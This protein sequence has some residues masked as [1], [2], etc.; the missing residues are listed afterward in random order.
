MTLALGGVFIH[1]LERERSG[2]SNPFWIY[3]LVMALWGNLHGG[4]AIG[5]ILIGAY[6]G[7]EVFILSG[8]IIK[9][10]TNRR[11]DLEL[12]VPVFRRYLWIVLISLMGL[13]LNPNGPA[14]VLYPFKT[15]S[16]G[17][18][19][20]YIQ[21]WQSPDFH[22]LGVQPFLWMLLLAFV[23]FGI[24]K[25]RTH[26]TDYLLVLGFAVM[27]FWAARNIAIFALAAIIPISRAI[28]SIPIKIAWK[29]S[30]RQVSVSAQRYVNTFLA[31][32]FLT[33]ALLKI[34]I[35][36]NNIYNQ[37]IIAETFPSSAITHL[38]SS[39]SPAPIF[40]SYNWGAYLIWELYPEYRSFVDGRTDLFNDEILEQYLTAWRGEPGWMEI[41]DRWG[42]EL[43]LIEPHSPLATKL[44]I[45]GWQLEYEDSQSVVFIKPRDF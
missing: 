5:F 16:I 1:L 43:V 39:V 15:V 19:R 32:V 33:A 35:P 10:P 13:C 30:S 2:D 17:V 23:S 40:N 36:G 42:I 45:N 24:T 34:S 3:L 44:K 8:K 41:F 12:A 9:N 29:P 14:M 7:G 20:D 27:S 28:A 4:F 22:I 26:P 11:E 25:K 21:E 31:L 38:A 37:E 18:L 6:M